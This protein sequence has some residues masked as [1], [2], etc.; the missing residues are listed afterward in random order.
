MPFT[1]QRMKEKPIKDQ[2]STAG[3]KHHPVDLYRDVSHRDLL[4]VPSKLIANTGNHD[5][6]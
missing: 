1:S 4:S 2:K 6:L 3:R 5:K